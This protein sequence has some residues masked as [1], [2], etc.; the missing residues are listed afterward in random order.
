MINEETI[1][2]ISTPTGMGGI[3]IIRIS[4]DKAFDICKK[5]FVRPSGKDFSDAPDFSLSYGHIVDKSGDILDEV[6]LGKMC[7]PHTYTTEDVAEINCHGG[8]AAAK[9]IL[10]LVLKCGARIAEPGEFTK[11]A[12]LGG[13]IDL[14]QA[15]AV[16]DMISTKT[17]AFSKIAAKQ[18]SGRLREAVDDIKAEILT[19]LS[20]LEV[21]IQYPEYD[22]DE[23]TDFELKTE[24]E[25]IKKSIDRLSSSFKKGEILKDGLKTAI[26]GKPNVGKSMLLNAILNEDKAIVTDIPGTTRDVIDEMVCI[27]GI[28]IKLLDTAGIRESLDAVESIGIMR[29]LK[30]ME[31]SDLTL[32]VADAASPLTEED[33]DIYKKIKNKAHIVVLNKCDEPVCEDT[34]KYFE[35]DKFVLISAKTGE[36]LK[37][38]E[39]MISEFAENEPGDMTGGLVLANARH[40]R[41]IDNAS[42]CIS[43]ALATFDEGMPVDL[44]E[45][46][47]R[48]AWRSLGE[49]TGETA[50]EDIVNEIFANFCLG[51]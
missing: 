24:L 5:I 2:A 50:D 23:L 6:L 37:E 43:Q 33:T 12:F 40:K 35:N 11:R 3:A 44:C 10:D 22:I 28:P 9:S 48:N 8:Y 15:E 34:L 20:N 41:L 39:R 4:G 42:E 16:S 21:S 46:D 7:S 17:E 51:K 18:I 30:A 49:I 13:R 19:L 26:V 31:E 25:Q 1:A 14:S 27:N 36:N 29:S 47:I 32:F 45:I 38:A